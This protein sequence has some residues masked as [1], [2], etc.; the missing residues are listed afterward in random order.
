[1]TNKDLQNFYRFVTFGKPVLV[2]TVVF[3][4]MF[5][6]NCLRGRMDWR[7][8]HGCFGVALLAAILIQTYDAAYY[9]AYDKSGL[10]NSQKW[11][12]GSD[13]F[14]NPVVIPKD[15]PYPAEVEPIDG[16]RDDGSWGPISQPGRTPIPWD[17]YL[18]PR[19]GQNLGI[20]KNLKDLWYDSDSEDT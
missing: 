7:C 15:P 13:E 9:L 6:T 10:H 20:I 19:F 5:V 14:G 4:G 3:L 2:V 8:V 18:K 1:M 17:K 12:S 16:Y 11:A